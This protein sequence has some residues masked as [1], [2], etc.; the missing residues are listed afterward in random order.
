MPSE[1]GK[2][3][4]LID[5]YWKSQLPNFPLLLLNGTFTHCFHNLFIFQQFYGIHL[6]SRHVQ[7]YFLKANE[8]ISLKKI[9]LD[10]FS[11]FRVRCSEIP[12]KRCL[13]LTLLTDPFRKDTQRF[14]LCSKGKLPMCCTKK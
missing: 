4:V 5:N 14:T 11:P 1:H 13:F 7:Y 12:L 3:P 8:S 9:Y 2:I 6:M 10:T